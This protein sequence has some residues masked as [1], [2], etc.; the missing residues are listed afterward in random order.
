MRSMKL[1]VFAMLVCSTL[2][3]GQRASAQSP[4]SGRVYASGLSSPVAFIQDSTN[5]SRQFVVEQ[6][7]RIRVVESGA[8][9]PVDFLTLSGSISC[10]GER[11]LL[12]MALS[13]DYATSGRFYVN[14][15]DGA[16]NTVIARFVRSANPAVANASSRFDLQWPSGLRYILQPYANHNSGNLAFGPDGYLY[17][18]LGDG[19]SGND[20]ENR[21]QNP[22][23]LLGKALRIDVNV[24]DSNSVGYAIPPSN[25]FVS[26]GPA[27]VLKEIW[28]FGLRNPW[29]YSFDMPS[30]GGTGAL[31]IAD[32]GQGAWEEVDYEPAGRGGRNYGWRYR[33]GAH[34]NVTNPAPVYMPAGG[35][36]DP[37]WEYSHSVG[38]SITGGFVYRGAALPAIY[39]GRYFFA[40]YVQ[41]RVWSMVLSIN[42]TTGEAT[43]STPTDH[44]AELGGS[45]V[46]G[47]ISSFGIDAAGELYVVNHTGGTIVKILSATPPSA[48]TNLR[49]IR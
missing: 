27:G 22:A 31:I 1:T 8:V 17:I 42:P 49:I 36:T 18:A 45:P 43:A 16:G 4:L 7:G 24:P 19:G 26:G 35:L 12:G 37:I 47:N 13:P 28:S 25:P 48:P 20:P 34:L 10:C 11:G 5:N 41:G 21:A 46:I 39:R 32:V 15:T 9:L 6:G 33:E 3:L 38:Q 44:T 2:F 30:R 14:F 29:R 40:D 23:E